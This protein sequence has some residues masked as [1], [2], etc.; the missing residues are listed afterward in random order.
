MSNS[1]IWALSGVL[2][3]SFFWNMLQYTLIFESVLFTFTIIYITFLFSLGPLPLSP[4]LLF[5]PSVS[6]SPSPKCISSLSHFISLLSL[7]LSLSLYST[8][9]PPFPTKL[10]PEHQATSRHTT[11][12]RSTLSD[13]RPPTQPHKPDPPHPQQPMAWSPRHTTPPS[14]SCHPPC[15]RNLPPSD[16]S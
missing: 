12:T 4:Y 1:K 11:Q 16:F 7:S 5:R 15:H 2:Y 8:S 9:L 13:R 10:R 14:L 3:V 6:S